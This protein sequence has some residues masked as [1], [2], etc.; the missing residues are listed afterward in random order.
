M[1]NGI[2]SGRNEFECANSDV[3]TLITS[4]ALYFGKRHIRSLDY[5]LEMFFSPYSGIDLYF[6]S[7]IRGLLVLL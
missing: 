3:K 4:S 6:S 5:S 2:R 1:V 7:F